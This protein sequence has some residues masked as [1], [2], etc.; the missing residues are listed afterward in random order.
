[1]LRQLQLVQ[2]LTLPTVGSGHAYV[3]GE[4]GLVSAWRAEFEHLGIDPSSITHKAYWGT[5]R[6]NATHGE[7]LA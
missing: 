4:A 1:L 7:P 5:G 6:V 2:V 3:S